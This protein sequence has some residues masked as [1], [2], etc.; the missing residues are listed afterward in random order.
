MYL[1]TQAAAHRLGVAP[2][3]LRRWSASGIVP[4]VRT[5]GGH[6]RF[7]QDDV[8]EL[9][10]QSHSA[11]LPDAK[12]ARER[13]LETLLEVLVTLTGQLHLV[14]LLAEIAYQATRLLNCEACMISEFDDASG[15]VR[16]LAEFDRTGRRLPDAPAYTIKDSPMVGRVLLQ[17]EPVVL[18]VNDPTADPAE[19][20]DMRCWSIKTL[21]MVPLANRGGSIGL[22]E[23]IDRERER[24]FSPQEL[25]IARAIAASASVALQ[26]ARALARLQRS[27]TDARHFEDAVERMMAGLSDVCG[28]PTGPDVLQ[29][30]AALACEAFG[31]GYVTVSWADETARASHTVASFG[32]PPAGPDENDAHVLACRVPCGERYLSLTAAM[33]D[34][35]GASLAGLARLLASSAAWRIA[36]LSSA[37][38]RRQ[39]AADGRPGVE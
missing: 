32:H 18:T 13:E 30:T 10:R 20:N 37:T 22:L 14:E 5:A 2:H 27:D 21:L 31:C 39:T 28:A 36:D 25:R 4:C 6:R 23:V 29:T 34:P 19:T 15:T 16:P 1:S 12:L 24:R 35:P 33:H 38:K 8:D 3:T 26:S 11:G 17:R 7:R 9:L